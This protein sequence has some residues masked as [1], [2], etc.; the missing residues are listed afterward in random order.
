[1]GALGEADVCDI[2]LRE[3]FE[4]LAHSEQIATTNPTRSSQLEVAALEGLKAVL[5]GE[6][7]VSVSAAEEFQ[8]TTGAWNGTCMQGWTLCD[9]GKNKARTCCKDGVQT[10][11][12]LMGNAWC[13]LDDDQKNACKDQGGQ[14][15]A[16]DGGR[17][18]CCPMGSKCE[19]AGLP[20]R[21]KNAYCALRESVCSDNDE[22]PCRMNN[23]SDGI[24]LDCC[25]ANE[26]CEDLG[27]GYRACSVKEDGCSEGEIRCVG[28]PLS[29]CCRKGTTCSPAS[30]GNPS[31]IP[32]EAIDGK[33]VEGSTEEIF[34]NSILEG[35]LN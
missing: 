25:N 1:M 4:A 10:C 15:C 11:R 22:T 9:A 33:G 27:W 26:T 13:S 21:D 29:I 6:C 24:I 20:L 30:E 35:L 3:S 23:S 5:S 8:S 18:I 14:F 31:C 17:N 7:A 32:N 2:L 19:K 34:I 28:N 12:T 16:G